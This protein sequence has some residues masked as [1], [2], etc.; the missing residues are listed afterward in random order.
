V[1]VRRVVRW[2]AIGV[3]ATVAMLGL[4]LLV[5]L[6]VM[7]LWNQLVPQLFHG[8]ELRYWQALGLLILSRLLVGG[9]RGGHGHWRQRRWRER[10]EQ[11]SPEERARL[12][13]RFMS[14]CARSAEP[15]DSAAVSPHP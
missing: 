14:G 5:G 7:L 8:P 11:M 4:L 10:W 3:A 9:L 1:S 2:T 6:A 12:R 13:G 15:P